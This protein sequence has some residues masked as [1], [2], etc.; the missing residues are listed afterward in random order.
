MTYGKRKMCVVLKED[1]DCLSKV[2]ELERAVGRARR[3]HVGLVWGEERLVH[4][5]R[6]RLEGR[7]RPRAVRRP[8]RGG[9]HGAWR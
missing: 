7:E 8:L 2:E 9:E 5:G 6:V 1:G 3:E 4:A